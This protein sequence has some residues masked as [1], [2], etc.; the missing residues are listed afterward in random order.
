ME[1]KAHRQAINYH[2][3][4]QQRHERKKFLQQFLPHFH[5][6][7][8]PEENLI[9]FSCKKSGTK[10][11]EKKIHFHKCKSHIRAREKERKSRRVTA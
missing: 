3:E 2:K 5:N 7:E 1:L 8:A 9:N 10:E 11:S 4:K 6:T